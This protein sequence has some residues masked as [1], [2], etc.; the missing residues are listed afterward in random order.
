MSHE[1]KVRSI[2]FP[3][4]DARPA[5][6]NPGSR[7]WS[8]MVNGASLTMPYLEPFLVKNIREA[9]PHLDDPDLIEDAQA[10]VGQ[11]AQHFTNHRRYN[12]MLKSQG[13][14][15]LTQVEDGFKRGYHRLSK[16]SLAWRL[17]YTA[18]FETMTMGITE[19]LINDRQTLFKGAD[20]VVAS[21]ILW[22]M[23]EETEHKSVAFDVY[24]AICGNY[25]LRLLGL[26]YGSLHVGFLS[27]RGYRAMLKTDGQWFSLRSR[28][29]LWGMVL[30]F[31]HKA[32]WVMI[33]AMNPLHHPDETA[34]PDWV[35]AWQ[36]AYQNIDAEGLPLLNTSDGAISPAKT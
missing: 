12:E 1:I 8:H 18:G 9:I 32:G 13:Y 15:V 31:F 36:R 24:Q 30:R 29:R 16:R 21:F 23:V 2:K 4:E 3:F 6:W 27:R 22:H 34:D 20:P 11:E 14:E 5:V 28:L 33:R 19:W 10:F 26:I 17:A 25:P 7:E 35:E